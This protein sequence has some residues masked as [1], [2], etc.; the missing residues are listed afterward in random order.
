M[1]YEALYPHLWHE[2]HLHKTILEY[3]R[4]YN[5]EEYDLIRP[6]VAAEMWAA[7]QAPPETG[8]DASKLKLLSKTLPPEI[9][10]KQPVAYQQIPEESVNVGFDVPAGAKEAD[11]TRPI[12]DSVVGQGAQAQ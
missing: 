6:A 4:R 10:E 7:G 2:R 3:T 8:S 5:R 9:P 12:N 1:L 11:S